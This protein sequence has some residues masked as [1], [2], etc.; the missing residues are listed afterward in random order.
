MPNGILY[1]TREDIL[2]IAPDDAEVIRVLK[3]MF[4]EKAA[5]A[6]EMP[7]KPGIHPLQDSF[8]HAMPAYVPS[9]EA[10]GIKWVS[11]YPGNPARG[12][13]QVDGLIILNDPAT[14]LPTAILDAGWVTAA[15]T[16][17]ASAIAAEALARRNSEVLAILG[18][19]T[20]GRSHLASLREVFALR[21][22]RAFDASPE[23]ARHYAEEMEAR[24]DIRVRSVATAEEAVREA[25]LV[26]TAGPITKPAH[27]TLTAASISQGVFVASVDFASYWSPDALACFDRIATDDLPQ[28]ALYRD[29]GY[30]AGMPDPD[31]ELASLVSGDKAGRATPEQRTLSCN[32]GLALEDV[33][34]APLIVRRAEA[35][36]IGRRL[37][38]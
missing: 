2:S 11:A 7:P 5:G 34:V 12:L 10:A 24:H 3:R 23:A 27:A 31:S 22:V 13:P 29:L 25:D 30:F 18:C 9:L 21:E 19:G 26:V 15:R 37:P 8:L 16:A 17:A 20:Q 4:L 14:G 35:A 33:V 38:R 1:L 32:L 28:F 36:G 6:V